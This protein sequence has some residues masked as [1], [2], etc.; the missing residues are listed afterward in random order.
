MLKNNNKEYL[1]KQK[2]LQILSKRTKIQKKNIDILFKELQNIIKENFKDN[3]SEKFILPGLLKITIKNISAQEKRPGIN[4]FTKEKIIFKEKPA[5]KK[6]KIK[7][8][9]KLKDILN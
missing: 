4:P 1:N 2:L 8:L 7:A 3:N 9:K 6:I 5:T